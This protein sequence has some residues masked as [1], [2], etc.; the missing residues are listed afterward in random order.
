MRSIGFYEGG[1]SYDVG[2][3]KKF[4][5]AAGFISHQYPRENFQIQCIL[6]LQEQFFYS[7]SW[8]E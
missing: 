2:K 6:D 8:L 3:D 4:R 1:F 7:H 5:V